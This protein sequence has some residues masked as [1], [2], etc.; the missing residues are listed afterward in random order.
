M[1][2]IRILLLLIVPCTALALGPHEVLVLANGNSA[3]SVEI[4][5]EFVR[6]RKVPGRNM[7]RLSLPASVIES[8]ARISPDEFTRLIW[9]PAMR[10]ARKR[11]IEGHILAWVYSVD[12]PILIE[13]V[14][15][16]SLQ[17]LTFVRN[18]MPDPKQ[19]EK[20][21]YVSPLFADS[22]NPVSPSFCSQ[23]LDVYR[24]WLGDDMPLPSMMLGYTGERGSTKDAVLKCIRNG[25]DSDG[26]APEGTV[27]FVVSDNIRSTCRDWQFPSVRRELG[28]LGVKAVITR[29]F[30]SRQ[31][32]VIGLLMG[33]AVVNPA[34]DNLYV[35]GCMAEHLTSAA[36]SFHTPHQTKLSSWINAGVT[37]SAG[38][39]TEPFSAWTK[40]PGGRFF[41][42]YASGCSMIESFFQSIRCP[43]QILLVG[44]PLAQ[45]WAPKA[46]VVLEGLEKKTV[47]GIISV[48]AEVRSEPGH[49]YGKF[50]FLL[51]GR[52][53][54]RSKNLRFDSSTVKDGVHRLRAVAYHAGLVR[55]QV[56]TV[57]KIVVNNGRRKTQK[58]QRRK[59]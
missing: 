56:F 45:P 15:P 33:A 50:M 49:H 24:Q 41:V 23:T 53:V 47:S 54:G 11:G 19:V 36:A 26:S 31:K 48:R 57:K 8:P 4:A 39:V 25:V 58:T 6:L 55:S 32:D 35:P 10:A 13:S 21:I 2:T 52:V 27:Y 1:R 18:K 40:F 46:E 14:P 38:A 29:Q 16:I 34:Q 7:V 22:I 37:A 28:A 43:L 3:D 30:P 42:H 59:M 5:K 12:F 9:S 51:D 20:G 17:G 44:E